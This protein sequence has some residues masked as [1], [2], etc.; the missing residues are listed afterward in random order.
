MVKKLDSKVLIKNHSGEFTDFHENF[1]GSKNKLLKEFIWEIPQDLGKGFFKKFVL[2]SGL[3][4]SFSNCSLK[5]DYQ[6]KI[7]HSTPMLTFAFNISGSTITENSCLKN[8]FE[9]NQNESYVHYFEDPLIG[10]KSMN[11]SLLKGIS[12]RVSPEKFAEITGIE[13]Q[14]AFLSGLSLNG[15]NFIKSSKTSP[16]IQC[17]LSQMQNCPHKGL[18]KKIFLES[19]ALELIAYKME[20]FTLNPVKTS[21][22][23]DKDREKIILA[24]D[25]LIK[26]IKYPPSLLAISK[27]VNISHTKLERG[28]KKVFNCTVFEYLRKSRLEYSK[29]LL[30]EGKMTITET[31]FEAGFSS[32]SHFAASFFKYYGIRPGDYR[33]GK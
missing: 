23:S 5:R 29:S 14:N 12:I 1:S 6:A 10:R 2:G 24:R 20:E 27:A 11:H 16:I 4:I 8:N 17:T 9:A 19:K 15:K 13:N 31:A 3:E 28:F 26:D 22:I 33:R 18:I 32:S 25:L 21:K 7:E 30:D